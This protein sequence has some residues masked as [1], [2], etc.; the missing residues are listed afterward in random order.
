MCGRYTLILNTG[1]IKKAFNLEE[2]S[3]PF[4]PHYNIAPSQFV[5]VIVR[6][7]HSDKLLLQFFKWGLV[8]AWSKTPAPSYNTINARAETVLTKPTFRKI[9][10]SHRCLIPAD[11]FFE[12]DHRTH[13]GQPIRIMNADESPMAFAGLWDIWKGQDKGEEKTIY[14]FTILT[15]KANEL[16]LPIHDRMPV[17]IASQDYMSWLEINPPSLF[18]LLNL[19]RPYPSNCLR[20]YPVSRMINNPQHDTSECIKEV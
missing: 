5:P 11:S 10:A 13:P 9:F 8:P 18:P 4:Q 7:F 1:E 2:A 12:W 3:T 6:D 16:L 15:I 17:I 14:S 19:L 20:I